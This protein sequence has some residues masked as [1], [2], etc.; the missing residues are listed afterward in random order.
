MLGVALRG[1]TWVSG[2]RSSSSTPEAAGNAVAKLNE[3]ELRG[4]MLKVVPASTDEQF[5]LPFPAVKVRLSW[6]RRPSKGVALVRCAEEN[7]NFIINDCS[8][9]EIGGKFIHCDLSTKHKNCIFVTGIP[10][11]VL[12]SELSNALR[13]ATKRTIFDVHLL[14]GESSSDLPNSTYAKALMKEIA[15]FM[16]NKQF[17]ADSFRV[18]VFNPEMKDYMMK[19][20]ITFNGSLHLE[21]AKALDHIQG[22]V[23]PGFLSWQ[24]IECQH[25]FYST[26]SCP[27]RVYSVIKKDLDSLLRNFKL[28]KGVSFKLDETESGAF[29]LKV[30]ANASKVIADLRKPLEQLMKGKSISHPGLTPNLMQVLRFRDGVSLM[31]AV[32]RET[33]TCILY[34]RQNL[35]VKVFGPPE[36]VIEAEKKLIN[37]L[38]S[39]HEN[40]QLEIRLR[41]SNRPP[42]LM[43][44]VVQRFGSDLQGLKE[45]IPGI[46]VV[47]NTRQHTLLIKGSKELKKKVE[48]VISEVTQYLDSE[49]RMIGQLSEEL[50]CP[51]CLCEPEEPYK[52]E[53][54]GHVFA[55]HA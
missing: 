44:E 33:R 3:L 31:S 54:C 6:P 7:A 34:D 1:K 42:G 29:R 53:S 13:S 4:S 2:A 28:H 26:L 12:D 40:K 37:A 8:G 22:K 5:I 48:D 10:K 23:L 46:E 52:L 45:K 36:Q 16:P 18:E 30:S 25:M 32:E 21:A 51:I 55:R 50:A 9:L 43:K 15:P 19:A 47:L 39:F 41:G 38:L 35:N 24:K 20:L 49:G 17:H 11:D 27:G 14:R